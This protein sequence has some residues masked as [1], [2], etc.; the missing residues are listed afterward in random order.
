MTSRTVGQIERALESSSLGTLLDRFSHV[1]LAG[2]VGVIARVSKK[3]WH[4]GDTIGKVGLIPR[5]VELHETRRTLSSHA[6]YMVV[7]PSQQHRA[8][9][10]A[11]RCC[12]KLSEQDPLRRERIDIGGANVTPE[13]SQICVAEVV[14]DDEQDIRTRVALLSLATRADGDEQQCGLLDDREG[15]RLLVC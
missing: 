4:G 13:H 11:H 5:Q 12:M 8:R 9:R 2:G 10:S 7:V 3:A 6:S 14:G 15:W 1:P